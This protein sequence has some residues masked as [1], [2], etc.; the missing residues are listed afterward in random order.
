[1]R[2]GCPGGGAY[3]AGRSLTVFGSGRTQRKSPARLL[4]FGVCVAAPAAPICIFSLVLVPW[5]GPG[6]GVSKLEDQLTGEGGRCCFPE[7]C[8]LSGWNK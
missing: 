1:M 2:G 7:D 3:N 6:Q 4:S 5:K 8:D